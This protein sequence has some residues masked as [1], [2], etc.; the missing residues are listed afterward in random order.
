[1]AECKYDAH[2]FEVAAVPK[3]PSCL[4]PVLNQL[5]TKLSA[6]VATPETQYIRLSTLLLQ[7]Y[8]TNHKSHRV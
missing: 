5:T 1:M 7:V 6:T 8:I 4:N 3:A 2:Y